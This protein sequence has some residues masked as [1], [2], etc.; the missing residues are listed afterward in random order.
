MVH[1]ESERLGAVEVDESKVL[2]FD[3]GL[4]GFPE[5]KRFAL[6]DAS[7]DGTY[8]WLQSLDDPQLAFL[9]AVPWAFFPDYEPELAE[10][11]QAALGLSTPTDAL[12]FCLLTFTDDAVTANLL[13][14]LVVN[15]NTR[16]GRQIVLGDSDYSARVPLAAA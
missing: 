3:H 12:V 15:A 8:Y 13:G 9:A 5:A 14:P 2:A 6:V 16:E 7:D 11:D 4:L 1:I 10:P